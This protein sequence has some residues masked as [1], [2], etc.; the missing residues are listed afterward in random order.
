MQTPE[1]SELETEHSP[2]LRHTDNDI[3][4]DNRDFISEFD[5]R[6]FHKICKGRPR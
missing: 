6:K 2:S 3:V 5:E 1:A 4:T